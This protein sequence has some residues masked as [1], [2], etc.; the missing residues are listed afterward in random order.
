[1]TES[2]VRVILT[3]VVLVDGGIAD[4]VQKQAAGLPHLFSSI[5][6]PDSEIVVHPASLLSTTGVLDKD[7]IVRGFVHPLGNCYDP[8]LYSRP[9]SQFSCVE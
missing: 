4:K 8:E 1:M 5:G 2:K 3:G 6:N 7:A 9:D